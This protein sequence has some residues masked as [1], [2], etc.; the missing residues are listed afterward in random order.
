M[1]VS[2]YKMYLD[3]TPADEAQ[4]DLF[5]QIKI[6]QGIGM[7][8]EA[9]L[10]IP[11]GVD[12]SGIWS[13]M[14]DDFV[15]AFKRIRIEVKIRDG[16]FVPLIDGPIVAHRYEL[17]G[18]P[19][20]SKLIVVVQDDSVLLNQNEGV[21]VYEN[22]S[23][24][25]VAELLF[26][27]FGLEADVDSV[28]VPSGGLDRYLVRRGTAM[29]FLRELGRR[30]GMFVYVEAGDEAGSSKGIFK[31]PDLTPGDYPE[32]LL[33]GA[34]RNINQFNAEFDALRPLKARAGNI[35]AV[36]QSETSSDVDS[37]DLNLLGDTAVHDIVEAGTTLLARTREESSDLDAATM[38]AVNHSSWAFT[39]SAEVI[40]D[41]YAGV[42]LPYRLVTVAG[43]GGYLS[44]DWLISHVTHTIT[45]GSYRQSFNL[46]RNA[47]SAG[48]S[49]SGDLLGG[50]I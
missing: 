20:N 48:A 45:D 14:E 13:V 5:G 33:V 26:N 30:Y 43:V 50:I 34:E 10:E 21:A 44:G 24:D 7:A 49:A 9:E 35:N 38:A 12:A 41:S 8:A 22:K 6:D 28:T 19:N 16:G 1:P 36:D 31:Y 42:L 4:L 37:S 27:E 17:S 39:A 46:R 32:L 47:R 2:E 11:I 15:Q 40:A 18:S 25:E 3:N 23:P 29:Q